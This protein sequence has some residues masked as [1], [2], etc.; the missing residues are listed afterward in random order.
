MCYCLNNNIVFGHL[1]CISI[2]NSYIGKKLLY[3]IKVPGSYHQKVIV[4]ARMFIKCFALGFALLQYVQAIQIYITNTEHAPLNSTCEIDGMTVSPCKR[5]ADL[6]RRHQRDS[7]ISITL[8][9]GDY[10]IRDSIGLH[11]VWINEVY[12]NSWKNK[13]QVRII[14]DGGG[15]FYLVYNTLIE[16]VSI[17]NVEFYHCGSAAPTISTWDVSKLTIENISCTNS[18]ESCITVNGPTNYLKISHCIFQGNTKS[19]G[20]NVTTID[21]ETV[22]ISD[23]VFE[24]NTSGALK[25]HPINDADSVIVEMVRCVFANNKDGI[26]SSKGAAIAV[27]STARIKLREY[28]RISICHCQFEKNTAYDGGALV[29]TDVQSIHINNSNFTSNFAYSNGGAIK[30]EGTRIQAKRDLIIQNCSFKHNYAQNGGVIYIELVTRSQSLHSIANSKFLNNGATNNGGAI[31]TVKAEQ[32]FMYD[33]QTIHFINMSNVAFDSNFAENGGA[34]FLSKINITVVNCSLTNNSGHQAS[35]I[36]KGGAVA[37]MQNVSS[38]ISFNNTMFSKNK[39]NSGGAIW[40]SSPYSSLILITNSSFFSNIAVKLG[41]SIYATGYVIGINHT[42]FFENEAMLGGALFL[43]NTAVNLL[44]GIY[45]ENKACTGGAIYSHE[46]Y[47]HIRTVIMLANRAYSENMNSISHIANGANKLHYECYT[48]SSGKGGSIFMEDRMQDC[49]LNSCRLTWNHTT[50]LNFVNNSAKFGSVLF[51]GMI[52]R[53]D[54]IDSTQIVSLNS[55]NENSY[56][57]SS[58]AIQFCFYNGTHTDCSVRSLK[59]TLYLGQS[60]EV[61]VACLDQVMQGK[62][63]V[64]TSQYIKTPEVKYGVGEHIRVIRG[65]EKLVFHAYSDNE[66]PF[67]LLTMNSDIMCTEDNWSSLE[68]NVSIIACPLGFERTG[69]RCECDHRLL[70]QL[71]TL[72]CLIGNITITINEDGWFG[73]DESYVRIYN[74]CPL[75]YCTLKKTIVIGSHPHVQCENNR[76]GILCTSCISNY[77]LALGSWKCK[78]CSGLSNYSFIWMTLVLA[79][80]GVLLVAFLI[81]LNITVS[82]GTLNGLILYANI[83]SVSGLLDYRNCSI[84]PFL[85]AFISWVNLDLGIEVCFYS[86]MDVYQK[87]WLQFVFPFY[88]WFLVGIIIIICHYSIT[89]TKLMGR[90]NIEVLATLF[91][92]SYTKLLKTIVSTLSLATITVSSA[93]NVSDL[94]HPKK[95]WLYDAHLTYLGPKHWP[96]FTFALLCLVFLFLPYTMLLLFGQ[97]ITYVPRKKVFRWIH[98]P[99]LTTILDAYFAPYNKHCRYWTG[100]GL[101]LR[102][103]LFS[104]LDN[105]IS[106]W[107]V[108]CVIVLLSA[109]AIYQGG[110]YE[111]KVASILEGIFLAN[112]GIVSLT[113]LY[114]EELCGALTS[115]IAISYFFF[116][117]ITMYHVYLVFI[118]NRLFNLIEKLTIMGNSKTSAT[119]PRDNPK[120]HSTTTY[121]Q[122]RE[123]L[124]DN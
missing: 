20:I 54:R 81:L 121:V 36:S 74:K 108:V 65:L 92:L 75:K 113:L 94:L 48:E 86:G 114:R 100:L 112:L 87:T 14:C 31:M 27:V 39:A 73:Y 22:Y 82:S 58:D 68:V 97:C 123:T 50:S 24:D 12:F 37:I 7:S 33:S 52:S 17:S 63:C 109:H 51:G 105:S 4:K 13:G 101:L 110:I 43:N 57:V 104:A 90:R 106:F 60:F 30:L 88:V 117:A 89:A 53:C 102:C 2:V 35:N 44:S 71:K 15:D 11:F 70:E 115:S 84:N 95:V 56:S 120:S 122:L 124:L 21:T 41:G 91:L 38:I 23:T 34:L 5:L 59:K 28:F 42:N 93:H 66:E 111:K 8:L 83:L 47:I 99:K 46:S 55:S 64:I 3:I 16:I 72:K 116:I 9:P 96:L 107:T 25:L 76:G 119:M 45:M 62:Y 1:L 61:H 85:R 26:N 69:D 49:P 98:S 6:E 103:I 79:L 77:S 118:R 18:S 10:Y 19:V 80:A 29:I 32:I 40:I 78:N 67:G